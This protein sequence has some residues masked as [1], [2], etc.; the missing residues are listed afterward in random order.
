MAQFLLKNG[1]K[2]KIGRHNIPGV[3]NDNLGISPHRKHAI[4]RTFGKAANWVFFDVNLLEIDSS[5]KIV[6]WRPF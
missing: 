1:L 4:W 3:E 5:K 2:K 6:R